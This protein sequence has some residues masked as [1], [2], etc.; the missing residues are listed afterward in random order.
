MDEDIEGFLE[1]FGPAIFKQEVPTAS[2]ERYRGHLPNKLLQYWQT[3]GWSGYAD[4]L[5][6]TVNPDE[7][8]PVVDAWLGETPFMEEDAYHLIARG[9]FGELHFFGERTG[10]MLR[11]VAVDGIMMPPS[12]CSRHGPDFK[13]QIFFGSLS[14]DSHDIE[15]RGGPLFART[16]KKLG[17]LRHDEMYGFVPALALGG[18]PTLDHVQKVKAVEHLVM[19]AQLTPLRMFKL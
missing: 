7:F 5:F 11:I 15:R 4:G 3:Y 10:Q 14:R 2:L 18:T 9:A 1:D 17:P 8:E 13:I 12:K 6:W 19:L 16:L